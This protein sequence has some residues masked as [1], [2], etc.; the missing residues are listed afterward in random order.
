MSQG[1][2]KQTEVEIGE[3]RYVVKSD[4]DSQDIHKIA[5][6]VDDKMKEVKKNTSVIS[7]S[8]IAILTALNVTEE[9]FQLQLQR[10][11]ME[12]RSSELIELL[13]EDM[14]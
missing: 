1:L 6:Y 8:Q 13:N 11:E 9:L 7:T 3:K 10:E 12:Q 2:K 5:K 14:S 4:L